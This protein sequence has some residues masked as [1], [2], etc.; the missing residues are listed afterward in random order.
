MPEVFR[1]WRRTRVKDLTVKSTETG[2]V[3]IASPSFG[4]VWIERITAW[5]ADHSLPCPLPYDHVYFR[6]PDEYGCVVVEAEE[7]QGSFDF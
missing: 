3:F 5:Q 2:E 7:T 1:A 6:Q 4:P